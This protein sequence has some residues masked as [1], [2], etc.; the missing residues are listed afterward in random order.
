MDPAYPPFQPAQAPDL[1]DFLAA[2]PWPFHSGEPS[3]DEVLARAAAGGYDGPGTETIWIT[4]GADRVGLIRL[5]DLADPTPLFDLRIRAAD[6]GRG[7]GA[8]ALRWLT[9]HVFLRYPATARIEGTTR[10]DN[11]AMRRAFRS[12]GFVK[13]AH[14]RRAW[15]GQDGTPH[16]AVGYAILRGDYESGR[17][18]P[19]DWDDEPRPVRP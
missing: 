18:T 14:Y 4:Q 17:T 8:A 1:A 5:W 15:P 12:A 3:R 7:L 2:G 6:R 10:Q 13:E 9:R 19:V 16:D 11:T